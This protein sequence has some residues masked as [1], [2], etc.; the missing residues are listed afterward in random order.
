MYVF[1][2]V[3]QLVIKRQNKWRS[4]YFCIVFYSTHFIHTNS[5]HLI[6]MSSILGST[7]SLCARKRSPSAAPLQCGQK[8]VDSH[9]DAPSQSGRSRARRRLPG[10]HRL[11]SRRRRRSHAAVQVSERASGC[12][13]RAETAAQSSRVARRRFGCP[14]ILVAT[15]RLNARVRARA[16]RNALLSPTPVASTRFVGNARAPWQPPTPVGRP[17]VARR[18]PVGR[19]SARRSLV[20]AA[21]CAC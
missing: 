13:R 10:L 11:V 19:S 3:A 9:S 4:R 16:A 15:T 21:I 6:S 12:K 14:K 20:H 1:C 17:S 7:L 8:G 18:S 2:F 5:A